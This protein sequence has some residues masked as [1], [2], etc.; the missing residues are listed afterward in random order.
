MSKFSDLLNRPLPSNEDAENITE[1][2]EEKEP[3]EVPEPEDNTEDLKQEDGDD[4]DDDDIDDEVTQLATN[5]I[6][7]NDEDNDNIS[8]LSDEE[9]A[10]LDQEL[11]G[12]IDDAETEEIE[13]TPEEEKEA[14]DMMSVAATTVLINNELNA[15]EKAQFLES[16]IDTTIAINE[17]L[18]L[19]SDINEMA[20]E[21][22]L[23]TEANNYSK[24]MIIRLDKQARMKQLYALAINVCAA[25]HG[26]PDY[27]KKKKLMKMKNVLNARLDKKYHAQAVK[28]SKIYM[29]RLM[30]SKSKPLAE[31]GKKI[32]K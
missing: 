23:M 22:G 1:S 13:L 25:A 2:A 5:A 27:A 15:E 18:L 32:Q 4:D 9:L 14:D 10:Q 3:M 12:G 31:L 8:D 29:K 30:S 7:D 26:D 21:C 17:G 24:K 16:K 19:E 6:D 20:M 28:R 11:T